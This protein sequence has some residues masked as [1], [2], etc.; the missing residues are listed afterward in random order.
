MGALINHSK[1]YFD[2]ADKAALANVLD[3]SFV[4]TGSESEKLGRICS[5]IMGRK[6][7]IPLQSGTDALTAAIRLSGLKKNERFAVPAYMC[8]AALD[9]GALTGTIPEPVDIDRESLAISPELVNDLSPI[10]AVVAAHLFGIPANFNRIKNSNLIE[11]CAQTLGIKNSDG[12]LA[13]SLGKFSIC[14]FYA[15]KLLSTGHGGL[16]SGNSP[17][18]Q[19]KALALFS[20]DKQ[21][22]WQPH[23]HFLMSDLNASLGVSQIEKL[24]FFIAERKKIAERFLAVLGVKK[25]MRSIF[26]RFLVVSGKKS[27]A[28]GL[29][30]EFHKSGIEAKSP[31]YKPLYKYLNR[32]DS[33]FPN[34]FWA[35]KNIVSVPIYPGMKENH[36]QIIEKFLEEKRNDLR[37]WPPA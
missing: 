32:G 22:K 19:R 6:W 30:K 7:G 17:R 28:E 13:G 21:D 36:I 9:A 2:N 14:S 4:S 10:E 23:L 12:K 16:I 34:A 5:A 1:P 15:T 31:V 29:I 11:D 3:K 18:M 8:S 24:S 37:C 20:H 27:F 25:N 33:E 35:H 26:S